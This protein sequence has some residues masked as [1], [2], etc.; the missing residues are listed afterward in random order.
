[1]PNAADRA[2]GHRSRHQQPRW[3]ARRPW[4]SCKRPP[5]APG[6]G[7]QGLSVQP[8]HVFVLLERLDLRHAGIEAA[9][10]EITKAA[11]GVQHGLARGLDQRHLAPRVVQRR[12]LR[13]GQH[14]DAVDLEGRHVPLGR[15]QLDQL[16][17]VARHR[18][19]IVAVPPVDRALL[20]LCRDTDSAR[21][22]IP[23]R[24][25][26]AWPCRCL[27]QDPANRSMPAGRRR[28]AASGASKT[29]VVS[30][31]PR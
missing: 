10:R 28:A 1:M 31:G 25:R 5:L 4:V 11:A 26:K 2:A 8:Q 23:S 14:L 13:G 27:G 29:G 19:E 18:R 21:R 6:S 16:A 7:D 24:R 17:R 12:F 20:E 3:P 22:S 30:S 9:R 15:H